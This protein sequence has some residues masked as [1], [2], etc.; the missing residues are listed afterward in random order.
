MH[1]LHGQG[2]LSVLHR[3]REHK[4]GQL[5]DSLSVVN[6]AAESCVKN[7]TEYPKLAYDSAYREDIFVT[8]HSHQ[9]AFW[10]LRM[11]AL[12]NLNLI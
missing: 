9:D 6:D 2:N 12:V 11:Y 10:E 1:V 7:I 5:P 4:N 8:V 3:T